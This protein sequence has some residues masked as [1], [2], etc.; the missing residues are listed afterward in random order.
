MEIP[1]R[2]RET[3]MTGNGVNLFSHPCARARF[4]LTLSA[5]AM[6]LDRLGPP[7]RCRLLAARWRG[8]PVRGGGRDALRDDA[9][10][11]GV[12]FATTRSHQLAEGVVEINRL[13]WPRVNLFYQPYARGGADGQAVVCPLLRGSSATRGVAPKQHRGLRRAFS[14]A[15]AEEAGAAKD[16]FSRR[17]AARPARAAWI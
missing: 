9:L 10:R 11:Y 15:G 5:G 8:L 12:S 4:S 6:R 3:T 16:G 1:A 2:S 7:G 17:D 14:P 13:S